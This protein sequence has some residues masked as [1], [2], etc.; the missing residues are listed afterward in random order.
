MARFAGP[1]MDSGAKFPGEVS[2]H[3]DLEYNERIGVI[4]EKAIETAFNHSGK[5][6]WGKPLPDI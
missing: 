5:E 2:Q 1:Q 6:L 4:N 3:K